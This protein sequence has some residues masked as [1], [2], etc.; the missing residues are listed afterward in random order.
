MKHRQESWSGLCRSLVEALV[1]VLAA[2]WAVLQEDWRRWGKHVAVLTALVAIVFSLVFCAISLGVVLAVV[3]FELWLGAWWKAVAMALAS[4]L[5]AAA[6]VASIAWVKARQAGDPVASARA[7]WH[8]HQ[9]WWRE[10]VMVEGKSLA[11]G[12]DEQELRGGG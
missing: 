6:V 3:L 11:E 9:R 2:E 5:L 4:T 1:E 8:D 10:Q 7:R 12:N